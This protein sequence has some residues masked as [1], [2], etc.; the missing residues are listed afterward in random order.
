MMQDPTKKWTQRNLREMS[1]DRNGDN[2]SRSLDF[3]DDMMRLKDDVFTA[4]SIRRSIHAYAVG[5]D[6]INNRTYDYISE[7]RSRFRSICSSVSMQCI[8]YLVD[9][10]F[11][12]KIGKIKTERLLAILRATEKFIEQ[13]KH[14]PHNDADDKLI[15]KKHIAWK[16]N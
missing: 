6:T 8:N 15:I 11:K 3:V 9:K 13:V 5:N 10:A 14:N 1:S 16:R 7:E 12:L 2:F 4:Q